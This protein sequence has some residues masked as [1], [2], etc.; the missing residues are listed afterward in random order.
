MKTYFLAK[1]PLIGTKHKPA[2][3]QSMQRSPYYWWWAYLRR[4][5]DYIACC[6]RGGKGKL[7]KLYVDFGD[8]R[9]DD[10]R[11]WW[12]GSLQRGQL[13]FAERHKDLK[14][15]QLATKD[16]WLGDWDDD[17]EV[18]V[19]AVNL[20]IGR[21]KLQQYFAQ[22]LSRLHTGKRGRPSV[23]KAGVST[24]LYPLHRNF[25]QHNL[26]TMLETYDA[27]FANQQLPKKEQV[28]LWT[29][30]DRLKVVPSAVSKKTDTPAELT[31]KHNVM[32]V[33]VHRYVKQAKAIVANTA[34]GQFPNSVT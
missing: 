22:M 16:E 27:W 25:S 32:S 2:A 12:G 7:A 19:F 4:N 1:H 29:I 23:G 17:Y 26:R 21:R 28:A 6:E 9:S 31:A 10:F 33:A 11:T 8:V 20:T 3:M 18:A 24:A 13:L 5:A 34:K 15:T 30:G 14:L